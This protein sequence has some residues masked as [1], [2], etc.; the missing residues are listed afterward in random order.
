MSL[1]ISKETS[2]ILSNGHQTVG[3]TAV[4]LTTLSLQF[5]RG[6]LLRAPGNNDPASN[7]APIWVGRQGVLASSDLANGGM[8]IPPGESLFIPI[9]DPTK[10]WLISTDANQDVAWMGM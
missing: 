5:A 2:S 6:V 9:D 1:H 3:T 10:I 4:Q 7:D 8:P